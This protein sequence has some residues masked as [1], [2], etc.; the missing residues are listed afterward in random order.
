[1]FFMALFLY[2]WSI[3]SHG[4]HIDIVSVSGVLC[5]FLWACV[6]TIYEFGYTWAV[7]LGGLRV[8]SCNSRALRA[9]HLSCFHGAVMLFRKC[10]LSRSTNAVSS[11][12]ELAD[13]RD[14]VVG[15]GTSG[16]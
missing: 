2:C 16:V 9:S 3:S 5:V 8:P 6:W 4:S 7:W 1:M 13:R 14:G 10:F 12:H 11:E 15:S